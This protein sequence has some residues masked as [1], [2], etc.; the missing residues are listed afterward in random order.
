MKFADLLN[1]ENVLA[2]CSAESSEA[3]VQLLLDCLKNTG[4][5]DQTEKA[6]ELIMER[7]AQYPTGIGGGVAI[8]HTNCLNLEHSLVAVASFSEGVDFG[9]DDGPARLVFLIL[10]STADSGYHLKLLARIS[11]LAARQKLME[12]VGSAT[13]P[14]ELIA[15]ISGCEK[16]FLDL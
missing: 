4:K 14:E 1:S 9:A 3:A 12:K 15:K 16:D 6:F 7:E 13:D 8:P 2:N 5:L 11:R 10:S